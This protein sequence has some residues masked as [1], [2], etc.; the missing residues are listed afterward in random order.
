MVSL[1]R[2]LLVAAVALSVV[3]VCL[4]AYFRASTREHLEKE[5][6]AADRPGTQED[7]I[8]AALPDRMAALR[9]RLILGVYVV[10]LSLIALV[11]YTPGE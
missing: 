2:L 1:I 7:F 11:V 10:P 3:F 5:W 9:T 8:Q 6:E 4:W